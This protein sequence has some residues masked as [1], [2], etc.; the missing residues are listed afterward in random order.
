MTANT[1]IM[2]IFMHQGITERQEHILGTLVR[3][4]VASAEPVASG[5]LV[6]K[7]RL[8]YSSA[9][10][11]SELVALDEAGY[12][13]QPHTSAGRIPTDRG[14]RFFINHVLEPKEPAVEN[15]AERAFEALAEVESPV[16]FLKQASRLVAHLTQNA[17]LAGFPEEDL[18]YKSGMSEVA[19]APE[20]IE[21]PTMREFAALL[22]VLDDEME[23]LLKTFDARQPIV[24]I[25]RENPIASARH[26]GMIVSALE[27]P[28][29]KEGV[30]ALIGP[31]RMDYARNVAIMRRLC[32]S[33]DTS[34]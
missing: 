7:Y 23:E 31:K 11:R 26:Y 2:G 8:P 25:G 32:E 3:E 17:V 5:D 28:F 27:T 13:T 30:I 6:Q 12:L 10:V 33:M 29:H 24:F 15:R 22:D 1:R 16:E 34:H 9:T 19:Q 21:A 4:Y 14:Y 18:F 20:F